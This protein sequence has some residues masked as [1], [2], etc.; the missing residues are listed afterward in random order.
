MGWWDELFGSLPATV[1][2]LIIPECYS[3]V[4]FG[5]FRDLK[6]SARS[7]ERLEIGRPLVDL[8]TFPLHHFVSRFPA[9][10]TLTLPV[11]ITLEDDAAGVLEEEENM[12]SLSVPPRFNHIENDSLVEVLTFAR[13]LVDPVFGFDGSLILKVD[14]LETMVTKFPLLRRLNVPQES[15]KHADEEELAEL[16]GS[17]ERRASSDKVHHA[18][19]FTYE[20][21]I[22]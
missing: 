12:G 13:P 10:T 9:I 18:G 7:I 2:T 1:Q 17:L 6:G 3:Y 21:D 19:I 15:V 4:P 8:E 14:F 11:T 5:V 22:T 20:E 16:S